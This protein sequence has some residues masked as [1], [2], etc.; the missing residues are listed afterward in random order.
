MF[1]ARYGYS[2]K[3]FYGLTLRQVFQLKRVIERRRIEELEVQ[4]DLHGRKVKGGI[5]PLNISKKKRD[6]YNKDA[7]GLLDRLKERHKE[8]GRSRVTDKD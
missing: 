1:A 5:K 4:A 6:E 2:L 8:H 3:D 7:L